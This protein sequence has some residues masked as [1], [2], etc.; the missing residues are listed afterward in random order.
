MKVLFIEYPKCTT[1]QKAKK[2]LDEHGVQY[3]DRHIKEQNPTADELTDW[4]KRSGLPLKR[5][6]NTSGLLYKSLGLKEKLP[7][8]SEAE[9]IALLATDGM[10]VKRPLIVGEDFV[11]VGFKPAE[12]ERLI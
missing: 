12:W 1:C 3:D 9:Q 2:W 7:Q 6:F 8:M 5:F 11:L 4:L 10:L